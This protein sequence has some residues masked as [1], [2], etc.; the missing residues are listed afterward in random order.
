MTLLKVR[1][2]QFLIAKNHVALQLLLNGWFAQDLFFEGG[3]DLVGIR[4]REI[5]RIKIRYATKSDVGYIFSAGGRQENSFYELAEGSDFLVLICMDK[6]EP[7][8]FYVFPRNKTP[9]VKAF[10]HTTNG[11]F[12]K[13]KEF[14]GNWKQLQWK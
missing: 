1:N 4:N 14:F 7:T 12:P 2:L 11:P 3:P 10:L 6:N 5:A 9:K 13:Y 8:G